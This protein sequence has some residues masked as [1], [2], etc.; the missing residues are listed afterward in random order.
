MLRA[1][2][3]AKQA[4]DQPLPIRALPSCEPDAGLAALAAAIGVK[5]NH[6][7]AQYQRLKPRRGH[8]APSARDALAAQRDLARAFHRRDLYRDLG[9][10]Y[11]TTRD[12]NARP[13]A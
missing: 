7:A 2:L 8:T 6:P 9:P 5:A 10:D 11:F 1:A 4:R 12:P 13:G 3:G